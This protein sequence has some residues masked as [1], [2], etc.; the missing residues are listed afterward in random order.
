MTRK[1]KETARK[2]IALLEFFKGETKK[3]SLIYE[4]DRLIE[5]LE[6]SLD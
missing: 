4:A 6:K 1:E 3:L 5:E 2:V